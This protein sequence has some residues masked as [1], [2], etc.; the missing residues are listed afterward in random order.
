MQGDNKPRLY[1][2]SMADLVIHA[3]EGLEGAQ[4][5]SPS[6]CRSEAG[7]HRKGSKTRLLHSIYLKT[8]ETELLSDKEHNYSVFKPRPNTDWFVAEGDA[9]ALTKEPSTNLPMGEGPFLISDVEHTLP[10]TWRKIACYSSAGLFSGWCGE[11]S[12]CV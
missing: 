7:L 10:G 3:V 12:V 9:Q 2:F 8:G 6:C 4:R 1:F 11:Q 5:V